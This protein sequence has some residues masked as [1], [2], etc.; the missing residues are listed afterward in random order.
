MPGVRKVGRHDSNFY[1]KLYDEILAEYNIKQSE[2]LN[3][4]EFGKN[5]N[6]INKLNTQVMSEISEL[7]DYCKTCKPKK[8]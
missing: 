7:S 2:I 4:S 1:Q 5:E 8:K 3:Q 6:E